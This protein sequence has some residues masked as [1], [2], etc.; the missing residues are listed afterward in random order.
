MSSIPKTH[1]PLFGTI[2]IGI[3][4]FL[5]FFGLGSEMTQRIRRGDN[6]EKF[7]HFFVFFF[8]ETK[9]GMIKKENNAL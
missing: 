6:C 9:A 8:S 1:P 3:C 4:G 7:V 5:E 2:P